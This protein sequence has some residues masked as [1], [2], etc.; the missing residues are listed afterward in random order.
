MKTIKWLFGLCLMA[1]V[2]CSSG[3]S[4]QAYSSNVTDDGIK[5]ETYTEVDGI[6]IM[7]YEGENETVIIPSEINGEP[8]TRIS[9]SFFGTNKI[10]HC[11]I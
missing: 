1:L 3:G 8:V 11:I 5:Y 10:K 4:V 6:T 2:V 9:G 7:G